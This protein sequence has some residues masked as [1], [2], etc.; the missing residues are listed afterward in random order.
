MKNF[1]KF[2]FLVLAIIVAWDTKK[3]N[4]E[5]TGEISE[6]TEIFQ[7]STEIW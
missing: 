1:K 2:L 3:V 7:S 5:I 6:I 4:N